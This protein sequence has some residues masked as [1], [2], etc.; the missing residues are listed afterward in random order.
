MIQ[1]LTPNY[2]FHLRIAIAILQPE[3]STIL[4]EEYLKNVSIKCLLV[5]LK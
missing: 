4:W 5:M 1:N 2:H 3:K